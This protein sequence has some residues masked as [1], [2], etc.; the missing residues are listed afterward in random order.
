MYPN[1]P[2]GPPPPPYPP[3]PRRWRRSTTNRRIAGVLGG[4]AEYLGVKPGVVRVG[5]VV[6]SVWLLAVG[7]GVL[8]YALAWA[9]VPEQGT[10]RSVAQDAFGGTPW[11]RWDRT[12]RSWVV[13]LGALVL[14]SV[15][16]FG[17]W[18][19]WHWGAVPAWL[20]L[21][22]LLVWALAR[23]QPPATAGQGG[24]TAQPGPWAAGPFNPPPGPGTWGA[25]PAGQPSAPE[26]GVAPHGPGP[27]APGGQGAWAPAPGGAVPPGAAGQEDFDRAVAESAARQWAQDQLAAAG[28]PPTPAPRTGP[29]PPRRPRVVLT[30]LLAVLTGILLL[31]IVGAVGVTRWSGVSFAGGIGAQSYAP[32]QLGQMG[33]YNEGIGVLK[34]DLSKVHFGQGWKTVSANVGIGELTVVV[35]RDAVVKLDAQSGI[36]SVHLPAGAPNVPGT[37]WDPAPSYRPY[38]DDPHLSLQAHVGIGEIFVSRA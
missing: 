14:L 4:L 30:A 18:P 1:H 38:R 36:G 24:A 10:G 19:W 11:D 8:L 35:P 13:V 23:H 6:L 12:A 34:V 32:A 25:Q 26:S 3:A 20:V 27:A 21:A 2:P 28:V 22:G 29:R 17:L 9:F 7:G 37:T 31:F 15:W 16:T 5:F 33:R